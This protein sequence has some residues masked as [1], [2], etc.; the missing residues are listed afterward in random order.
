MLCTNVSCHMHCIGNL[1]HPM[2]QSM[3]SS[4][5]AALELLRDNITGS[6][7]MQCSLRVWRGRVLW[8]W[9]A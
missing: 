1:Y 2:C 3:K 7:W 4:A 6:G 5:P 9:T 8:E